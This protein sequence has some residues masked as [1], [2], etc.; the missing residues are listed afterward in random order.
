MLILP[1]GS[2]SSGTVFGQDFFRREFK[3]GDVPRCDLLQTGPVSVV[4]LVLVNG[5]T[6]D[7]NCFEEFR[8]GYIVA[9]VFNDPP[10]CDDLSR[11]YIRYDAIFQVNV[12][13]HAADQRLG[14]IKHPTAI[15]EPE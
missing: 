9:T 8:R 2:G 5:A 1:D 12:R 7:V 11:T 6:L 15:E 3:D 14:F 4:E 10:Q 13:S